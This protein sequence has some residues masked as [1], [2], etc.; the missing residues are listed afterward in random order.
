MSRCP[1]LSFCMSVHDPTAP[2]SGAVAMFNVAPELR[3]HELVVL[4]GTFGEIFD[5]QIAH[6]GAD[7]RALL[8]RVTLPPL[9]RPR[10]FRD[11]SA[12]VVYFREEADAASCAE[13][14]NGMGVGGHAVIAVQLKL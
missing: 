2:Q 6:P 1:G 4:C 8:S 14:V 12:A 9:P 10:G 3:P 5:V 7:M 11:R 13:N